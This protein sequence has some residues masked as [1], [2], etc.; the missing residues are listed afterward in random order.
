MTEEECPGKAGAEGVVVKVTLV[1]DGLATWAEAHP[2]FQECFKQDVSSTLRIS[3]DTILDVLAVRTP[4]D[5]N[6]VKARLLSSEGMDVKF[7][8]PPGASRTLTPLM[9]GESY[10]RAVSNDTANFTAT[11]TNSGIMLTGSEVKYVHEGVVLGQG[12]SGSIAL[13]G[14]NMAMLCFASAVILCF[15]RCCKKTTKDEDRNSEFPHDKGMGCPIDTGSGQP[16][17]ETDPKS[18]K[19]GRETKHHGNNKIASFCVSVP[20]VAALGAM[21]TKRITVWAFA[22]VLVV[23]AT[24]I[25]LLVLVS[26]RGNEASKERLS[27][28][29]ESLTLDVAKDRNQERLRGVASLVR[30]GLRPS[31]AFNVEQ[32]MKVIHALEK[33]TNPIELELSNT[34]TD[35]E[36]LTDMV[37]KHAE[38]SRLN[39]T[40]CNQI[41]TSRSM[42]G[43]A[44]AEDSSE[45]TPDLAEAPTKKSQVVQAPAVLLPA[46]DNGCPI[47]SQDSLSKKRVKA[48]ILKTVNG[49]TM[50]RTGGGWVQ[51]LDDTA[52]KPTTVLS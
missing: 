46:L 49:K 33:S 11:E 2:E 30:L 15:R 26:R 48:V 37:R 50:K 43:P 7:S 34:D 36:Q 10:R 28:D 52:Q 27:K 47:K 51:V 40:G 21:I 35:D 25:L 45:D 17:A 29:I 39:E 22:G 4:E 23:N 12:V 3:K 32:D 13:V 6:S 38:K 44:Q 41:D 42:N 31:Y 9:L 5:D 18:Q 20:I 8:I 1:G 14:V 24:C 16:L 19:Q